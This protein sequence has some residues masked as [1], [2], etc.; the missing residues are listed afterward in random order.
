[1]IVTSG[2]TYRY[3]RNVDTTTIIMNLLSNKQLILIIG[4]YYII[5]FVS[6]SHYG[7]VSPYNSWQ[8]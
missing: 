3:W 4:Y 8:L 2:V 5:T 6:I 7:Y 1:M